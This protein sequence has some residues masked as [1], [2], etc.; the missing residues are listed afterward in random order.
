MSRE[1]IWMMAGVLA[2]LVVASIAG[3]WM[4]RRT[5]DEIKKAGVANFNA[6]TRSWWFM[7][8]VFALT[9]YLGHWTTVVLFCLISFLALR[10]F[11]TLN[12]TRTCDHKV[13]FWSFFI[14][15]PIQYFLV[16]IHWYGLASIFIPVYGFI[17]IPIR[18]VLTGEVKDFLATTAKIQ[19]GL[20]TC[21]YF[22]S[23][24]PLIMTLPIKDWDGGNAALL[25]FFVF[26]VQA[27]DVFQ[28]V[29]GKLLGRRKIA[30]LL[31]PNKT[32]EGTV[33]GIL[34]TILISTGMSWVTPFNPWQAALM[35]LLI[36]LAG[37]FG[38]LVMSAIKRDLGAKDWGSTIA[39][40][41]GV[42]DRIDSLCFAAP[43]FFHLTGFY[44]GT[45]MDPRPPEW[46]F[47]LFGK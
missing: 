11:I 13:L 45:G 19:W 20:L 35:S 32:V 4:A 30:P 18:K 7:V 47:G 26:T 40:H 33:G 34:T 8:G 28:Y 1:M 38:G 43:L 16:G 2:L 41:G 37:F 29:W 46:I 23:H 15:L 17:F 21:V 10:E 36:C 31:S 12:E 24:M 5:T 9:L 25:F 22:V 44:F 27:S 39:G 14:I 6:R 3:W 42:M